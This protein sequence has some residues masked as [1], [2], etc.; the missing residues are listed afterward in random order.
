MDSFRDGWNVQNGLSVPKVL[1]SVGERIDC[2]LLLVLVVLLSK[3]N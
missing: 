1:H 3:H 2:V